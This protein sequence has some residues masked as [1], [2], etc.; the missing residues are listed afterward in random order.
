MPTGC[1]IFLTVLL[2]L[3]V[4]PKHEQGR[5]ELLQHDL[6]RDI[7]EATQKLPLTQ[8]STPG[9]QLVPSGWCGPG[10]HP[11]PLLPSQD[12]V[13]LGHQ[14]DPLQAAVLG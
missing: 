3:G 12:N 5:T 11:G 13:R 8:A 7:P 4:G 10:A 9:A 1:S 6:P 14:E 2:R